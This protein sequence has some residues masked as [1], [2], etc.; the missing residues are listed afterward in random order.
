[1]TVHADHDHPEA[2]MF[3]SRRGRQ[4]RSVREFQAEAMH[5]ASAA[6]EPAHNG[7]VRPAGAAETGSVEIPVDLRV[8]APEQ[9]AGTMM[10]YWAPLS[11]DNEVIAC[12][13]CGAYRDWLV[14]NSGDRVWVRCRSAHET[15]VPGLDGDWYGR[16]SG[17]IEGVFGSREDG[18]TSF[19]YDGTFAGAIL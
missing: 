8:P 15:L 12:T 5:I 10:R 6:Q 17:P 1:M 3:R 7:A 19:G 18:L 13:E 2:P 11:V 14:L 4:D 9:F 16:N